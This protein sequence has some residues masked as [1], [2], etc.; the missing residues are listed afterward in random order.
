MASVGINRKS[1]TFT[2]CPSC[3]GEGHGTFQSG[4]RWTC[5]G[6]DGRGYVPAYLP[7]SEWHGFRLSMNEN[8]WTA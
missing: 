3:K 6:C 2:K 7:K 1:S 8:G 5:D 4:A